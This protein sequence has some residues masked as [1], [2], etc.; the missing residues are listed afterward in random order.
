MTDLRHQKLAETLVRYS[1]ALVPGDKLL[2]EAIDVPTSFVTTLVRAA[3]AAGALPAVLLKSAP[4]TRELLRAGTTEQWTLIADGEEAV[5]RQ[6][7]AY[8]GLRGGDNVSELADVPSERMALFEALLWKRVHL[9]LRVPR[10]RW[11]VT[12]WPGPSMAQL[13]GTSTAAFEELYFRVCTLDYARMSR[14]MAPL[15]A[16]LEAADRVRI[17]APGT[18]LSFSVRGIG[19][20]ACDGRRNLPDGEVYTAPVRDSVEGTIRYNTP[21]LY[22]GVTHENV[23]FV[24]RGGRI[25]EAS[26]SAGEA[27]DRLLDTD[28]GARHVGEFALGFNPHITAPMKDILFDEKIAGS[29]HFTP[30]QAYAAADNGNRS[31]VHWDLV[32]RMEAADGGGEIW[33][34]DVLIRKDGRFVVPDLEGLN[35][36]RL[37]AG[38][39]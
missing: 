23:R 1:C 16:R 37:L 38:E 20:V 8:I 29:I 39:G 34:D 15:K 5:M 28:D 36:E 9:D 3:A 33:F 24:F 19:A 30:G 25:V 21:S 22:R 11:V 31:Q 6:V 12:R 17:T 4:V 35:P 32:L 7:D 27:L 26:S 10:T 18:D 13:A 14:A 2:I